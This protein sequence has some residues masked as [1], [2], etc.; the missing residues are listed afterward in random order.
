MSTEIRCASL[1]RHILQRMFRTPLR[2]LAAG[3][4][5]AAQLLSVGQASAQAV[6]LTST[7]IWLP[8]PDG[9]GD[10]TFSGAVDQPQNATSSLL[11]GWVVDTTAQGWSGIDQ[12]QVW[13]GPM[14]AG[15][16]MIGSAILQVNRPDVA[17]SLG[18]PYFASSGYS[19]GVPST[20]W[21]GS[22]ILYIYAHTPSKGWWYSQVFATGSAAGYAAG[23][24]LDIETPTVLATVHA[25]SAYT[26]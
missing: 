1:E 2:A 25:N 6:S 7:S 12:V 4:L 26:I 11:T 18:N 23:P 14:G 10:S 24:R 15:G 5:V 13:N 22:N 19:A 21:S 20:T 16:Q 9:S 8:G 3:L 17:A